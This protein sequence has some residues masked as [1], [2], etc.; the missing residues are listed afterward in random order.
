MFS[1]LGRSVTGTTFA[2]AL[3]CV[4]VGCSKQ[5]S[6][7]P[8]AAAPPSGATTQQ[9][10]GKTASGQDV[11]LYTLKNAK[12]MEVSIAQ[13][14]A[15]VTSIKVPDRAGNFGDVT[16]GFDTLDG[17]LGAHPF[18]G[19]A[20]GR[21]GNRIGKG[22]FTLD[23]KQY[24]LPLNNGENHLHGGPEGFD[25]KLWQARE[26]SGPLGRGVEMTYISADGEQGYPGRLDVTVTY[27]LTDANE[28]RID[29]LA[30]TDKPTVVNLT[31]HTYFNL[32]GEGDVLGHNVQI[33]AA[34]FTPTDAGLIPTGEIRSVAGTPFDFTTPHSIGERIDAADEQIKFGKGYDHNWVLDGTAGELRQVAQV[35]EPKTGRVL[36]VLTTEPGLQF[37][38]GNF[39]D[40]TVKGKGGTVYQYRTG[41]C[42]ETQHFPDS[43]NKPN[44]PSTTL[45]PGERYQSTTVY[46]FSTQQ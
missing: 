21:Y 34:S 23:G 44:F 27:T 26:V 45:K 14:G 32:A 20:V 25:K 18:F 4:M 7:T 9:A 1:N 17:Y 35:S 15:T 30:V 6:E 42:M 19:V 3:S 8:G 36:E 13:W 37:Y 11:S 16:L 5:P 43:P 28:L 40:G 46:R 10:F 12:G 24:T 38:T 33:K 41:F 31:N 29:Y 2:V 22:K 39:L